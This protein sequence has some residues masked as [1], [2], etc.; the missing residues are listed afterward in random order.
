MRISVRGVCFRDN[1]LLVVHQRGTDIWALPGGGLDEDESLEAGVRREL[2]E[3]LGIEVKVGR[4]LF[5]QIYSDDQDQHL[6]FFFLININPE[7]ESF[8]LKEASHG[9][10]ELKA[11][12]WYKPSEVEVLPEFLHEFAED[13][14][15]NEATFYNYD[16]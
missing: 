8:D 1:K 3:E 10:L 4:L 12:G 6:E 11:A 5:S 15:P 13:T 9:N 7:V 16:S 14:L 2:R